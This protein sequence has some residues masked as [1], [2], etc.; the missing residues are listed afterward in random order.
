MDY[1]KISNWTPGENK[2]NS[3]PNKANL[4]KAQMNVNSL[5][6]KDYRKNDDFAVQKNK[7]NSNPIQ[8][9]SKPIGE[10]R[11]KT[12]GPRHKTKDTNL[13]SEVWS[14]EGRPEGWRSRFFV[15]RYIG[16]RSFQGNGFVARVERDTVEKN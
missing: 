3:N 7:P 13:E 15:S 6:T 12:K 4:H 10:D 16:S 9:Q 1:E 2:P 5:I 11:Y 14:L 8:S